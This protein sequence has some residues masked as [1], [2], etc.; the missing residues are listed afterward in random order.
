[1]TKP[2]RKIYI[3]DVYVGVLILPV[4]AVIALVGD[5]L[6]P[7]IVAFIHWFEK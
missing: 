4:I 2:R 3:P 1:M 6:L 7:W 5:F